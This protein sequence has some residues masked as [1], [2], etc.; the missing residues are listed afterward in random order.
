MIAAVQIAR[1]YTNFEVGFCSYSFYYS[2]PCEQQWQKCGE[3]AKTDR[4]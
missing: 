2:F 3:L 4:Q 1:D